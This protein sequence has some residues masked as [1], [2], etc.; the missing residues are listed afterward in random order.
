MFNRANP[1]RRAN[2]E[3]GERLHRARATIRRFVR[4]STSLSRQPA[5]TDNDKVA[6][7]CNEAE[8]REKDCSPG[9]RVC[10]DHYAEVSRQNEASTDSLRVKPSQRTRFASR[11]A[12]DTARQTAVA[13]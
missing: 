9:A 10:R 5:R 4:V 11:S 3:T 2:A 12:V 13:G 8:R 1:S 7:E 6:L